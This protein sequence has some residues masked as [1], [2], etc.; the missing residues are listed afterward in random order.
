MLHHHHR[1]ED[2]VLFPALRSR[3]PGVTT[4]TAELEAQHEELDVALAA[5]PGAPETIGATRR[6]LEAHLS[7][8]EAQVLPVWLDSFS[9]DEHERFAARLRRS[10]P[11]RDAGLMISWLLD[12]APTGAVG[13]AWAQVPSSLRLAHRWWWRQRYTRAFGSMNPGCSNDA[14]AWAMAA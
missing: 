3:N 6:L 7:L 8:E 10:T 2:E 13:V 5:L 9:A 14:M 11:L 4:T 1:A 12:T